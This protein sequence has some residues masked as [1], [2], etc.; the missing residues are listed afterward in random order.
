MDFLVIPQ[1]IVSIVLAILAIAVIVLIILVAVLFKRL[2][3]VTS[4]L[5]SERKKISQIARYLS[6]KSGKL[7]VLNSRNAENANAVS[8]QKVN[9]SGRGKHVIG[10]RNK[11]VI[12]FGEDKTEQQRAAY[13]AAEQVE[14]GTPSRS[15]ELNEPSRSV[16]SRSQMAPSRVEQA[17][18]YG[19]AIN[20]G[21]AAQPG[22][23]QVQPM[24]PSR[25][26]QQPQR[27]QPQAQFAQQ[28]GTGAVQSRMQPQT[29][30]RTV[31]DM[32]QPLQQAQQMQN[33]QQGSPMQQ[34]A[35]QTAQIDQ[36][37]LLQR[38]RMQA[39][40]QQAE[41]AKALQQAKQKA[42]M[43]AAQAKMATGAFEAQKPTSITSEKSAGRKISQQEYETM[44]AKA[45]VSAAW[46]AEEERRIAQKIAYEQAIA[47]REATQAAQEIAASDTQN[48][49]G[50]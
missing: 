46:A 37:E 15:I 40:A 20:F 31:Q 50:N 10:R 39:Q 28:R 17:S 26:A 33:A 34:R 43:M 7:G 21:Q 27:M 4:A 6:G 18:Q 25:A 44:Q 2:G 11:P 38:Q 41:R 32:Q 12:P 45:Q 47:I 35:G 8:A 23:Q 1:W 24:Q 19:Q 30:S 13:M 49:S 36:S 14:V 48:L 5:I 16:L 3:L 9:A 42:S 22:A 29:Q